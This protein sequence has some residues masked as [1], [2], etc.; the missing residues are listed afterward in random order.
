MGISQR[1]HYIQHL[2][3]GFSVYEALVIEHSG[4]SGVGHP[5][6]LRD[7]LNA[8]L[9]FLHDSHLRDIIQK[10]VHPVKEKLK[11]FSIYVNLDYN[12]QYFRI[13]MHFSMSNFYKY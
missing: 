5:G 12:F 1:I 6:L 2:A 11:I 3:V 4:Y 8:N 13:E 9:V 10:N 7:I